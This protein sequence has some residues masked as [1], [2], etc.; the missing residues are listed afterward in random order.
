LARLKITQTPRS[1]EP[2]AEPRLIEG[3]KLRPSR[4]P[5]MT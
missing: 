5:E 2:K 1:S 4:S 3:R